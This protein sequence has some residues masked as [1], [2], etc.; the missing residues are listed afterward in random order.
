[1]YV[2]KNLHMYRSCYLIFYLF[3]ISVFKRRNFVFFDFGTLLDYFHIFYDVSKAPA[4]ADKKKI[5]S[6]SI[7]NNIFLKP[8]SS[9]DLGERLNNDRSS[10]E[11]KMFQRKSDLR[12]IVRNLVINKTIGEVF[13]IGTRRSL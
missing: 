9:T 2:F 7:K 8:S 1:M 11:N 5:R 12:R 3:M 6:R 10:F 13:C 4:M